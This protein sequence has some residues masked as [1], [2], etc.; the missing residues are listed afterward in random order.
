MPTLPW[1]AV[2]RYGGLAQAEF[3]AKISYHGLVLH[4]TSTVADLLGQPAED[5]VGQSFFSLLPG[6]DNGPPG[7]TLN[8][9]D[10]SSPVACLASALRSAVNHETR[11]GAV[12]LRHKMVKK[13]GSQIDVHS[14][15]YVPRSSSDRSDPDDS[16]PSTDTSRPPSASSSS[17]DGTRPSSL[18]IQVKLV[19][20]S[21]DQ[22]R[23]IV[24]PGS[25]NVFEE[26]E[27]TRGTSWQYELHQLRLLNRRLKEDIGSARARGG[28]LKGFKGKKR[29]GGE[30]GSMP[31]PPPPIPEQYSAAPRH[32]LAPGFGLVAPSM[33]S[34]FY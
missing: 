8:E 14:I 31:P 11:Y 10:P 9:T 28:G 27:T 15:I 25:A 23:N 5:I 13:S 2:S 33:P 7:S 3:W 17:V 6:G 1:D 19:S 20:P 29:K 26:L 4:A 16:S 24:H 21:P 32:Q 18:V 22:F 30:E 34:N 12:S